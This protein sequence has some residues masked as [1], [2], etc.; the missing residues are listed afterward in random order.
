MTNI[1]VAQDDDSEG[2]TPPWRIKGNIEP[3][4]I[5]IGDSNTVVIRALSETQPGDI[6][7][8][9]ASQIKLLDNYYNAVLA[10]ATMSFRWAIIAAVVGLAFFL[11]AILFLLNSQ[12]QSIATISIVGG[13][14]VEV[15]SGINFFLY[16]KTTT[17]LAYFHQKLDQTQ[18]FLLA[19]SICESLKGDEKEKSRSRLVTIIATTGTDSVHSENAEKK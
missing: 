17:Q 9:A 2:K 1:D 5:V 13:T 18:R 19:N 6:Q 12:N 16:G 4:G 10:Q 14:L 8:I 11:G 3:S 15:I 7:K